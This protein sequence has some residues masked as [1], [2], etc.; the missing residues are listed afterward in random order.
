MRQANFGGRRV[1]LIAG[2]Q[3]LDELSKILKTFF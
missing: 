3:R 1:Q 2:Y